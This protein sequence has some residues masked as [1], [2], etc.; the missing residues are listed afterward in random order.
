LKAM[1]PQHP[2]YRDVLICF[3]TPDNTHSG[4]YPL[5]TVRLALRFSSPVMNATTAVPIR[6]DILEPLALVTRRKFRSLEQDDIGRQCLRTIPVAHERT[7]QPRN[8]HP[9]NDGARLEFGYVG[10]QHLPESYVS[11]LR[12]NVQSR[13]HSAPR[14]DAQPERE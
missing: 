6:L 12:P 9:R 7:R 14:H 11:R 4:K 13:R 2:T 1:L 8:L 10:E 5:S 3:M